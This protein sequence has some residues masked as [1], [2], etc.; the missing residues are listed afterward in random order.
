MSVYIESFQN[1]FVKELKQLKLKK[2]Q[3]QKKVFLAEGLN[4]VEE[5]P[6]N[7]KVFAFV[8]SKSFAKDKD[9][10]AYERKA[11]TYV[12]KDEIF[13]SL[14][15]TKT[16]QGVM[17]VVERKRANPESIVKNGDFFVIC[18]EV[19][20]PGN[21]GTIIRTAD[22]L[23]ASGVFLTKDCADLYSGKVLRSTM[24]SV[25]H[26]PISYGLE[27]AEI[28]SL[29]KRHG[30]ST[31]GAHLK[32]EKTPAETDFKKPFALLIGNETKGLSD[33]VSKECSELIKI[34]MSGKAE[35]LNAA[36]AAA[37]IMYEALR[38]RR[39]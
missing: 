23:G 16:P 22:A 38:Q 12:L 7:Y 1:K 35:S 28:L 2:Y 10:S 27:A 9:L 36:V 37:I 6:R 18:E 25:F 17:A 33:N 19:R 3:V 21:L 13:V 14:S 11:H 31:A 26:I 29:M 8:F 5:I 20:D 15:D 30:I 24:G 4:F 39:S 34:P 32:G